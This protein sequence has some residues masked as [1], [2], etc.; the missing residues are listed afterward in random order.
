MGNV[1]RL[2]T[3]L[4]NI[5]GADSQILNGTCVVFNRRTFRL[6]V[7]NVQV[8][9]P[10]ANFFTFEPTRKAGQT[11]NLGTV[12]VRDREITPFVN[13]IKR[14]GGIEVSAIGNNVILANPVLNNVYLQN[15]GNP[16]T[17]ARKVRNALDV[18]PQVAKL[19]PPKPTRAFQL[20]CNRFSQIIGG[21]PFISF[22]TTCVS[23]RSRSLTTTIQGEPTESIIAIP[24]IFR[25]ESPKNGIALN[26]GTIGVLE[27]EV[28]TLLQA[29]RRQGG[30][31]FSTL[32]RR[33]LF[34]DPQIVTLDFI[35][36]GNPLVF[37]RKVARIFSALGSR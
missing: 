20:L 13:V 29:V 15:V 8:H 22:S 9:D 30:L 18:L 12:A 3:R 5:I 24:S 33:F 37:A 16:I 19:E 35:N 14:Q 2:C 23:I 10:L 36:K 7:D 31:K 6:T 32:D 1:Q 21:S 28:N 11:L 26:G 4:A 34:Q 27:R 25:F 17:F